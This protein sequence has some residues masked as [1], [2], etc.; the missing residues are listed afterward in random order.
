MKALLRKVTLMASA[1]AALAPALARAETGGESHLLSEYGEYFLV[2]GGVTNYTNG[3]VKDRT[4]M[5]GTWDVRLGLGSRSYLGGEIAY[6]GSA[7][8][9]NGIGSDLY[10]NGIEGV[11]RLQYPYMLDGRWMIEPFAFGGVGWSHFSIT[12]ATSLPAH[13]SDD[14]LAVPVGGGVTVAHDRFL[15]DTRFTWRQTFKEQLIRDSDGSYADLSSW[16]VTMSVGYEF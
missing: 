11:L 9:A 6:V 3:A 10:S 5:G 1:L 14:A 4:D 12:D 15:L 8:S 2:G 16:A 7:R 13:T